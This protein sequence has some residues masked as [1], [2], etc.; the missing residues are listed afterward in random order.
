MAR[1]LPRCSEDEDNLGKDYPAPST[2]GSG[3]LSPQ[4]QSYRTDHSLSPVCPFSPFPRSFL[5]SELSHLFLGDSKCPL[6]LW[7]PSPFWNTTSP[8]FKFTLVFIYL[9]LGLSST[10]SWKVYRDSGNTCFSLTPDTQYLWHWG[11]S[12]AWEWVRSVC[13]LKAQWS[14]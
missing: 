2:P 8:H 3:H 9:W 4:P 5:R 14:C 10:L 11:T 6:P 12:Q 13:H 1:N 7:H